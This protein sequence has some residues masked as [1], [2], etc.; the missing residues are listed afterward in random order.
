MHINELKNHLKFRG[1]KI[2]GNKN[3]L[4]ASVFSAMEK[5]YYDSENCC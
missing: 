3:K 4:G 2:S 1:L 5:K